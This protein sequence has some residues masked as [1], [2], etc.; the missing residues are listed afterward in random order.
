MLV[1]SFCPL[2]AIQMWH[3]GGVNKV[4]RELFSRLKQSNSMLFEDNIYVQEHDYALSGTF[5]F[6]SQFK[7]YISL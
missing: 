6:I 2:W 7:A 5:F 3:S 4:S 1:V